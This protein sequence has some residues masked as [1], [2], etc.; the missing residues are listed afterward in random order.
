MPINNF[1]E[2]NRRGN[3]GEN[4]LAIQSILN[5]DLHDK[6]TIYTQQ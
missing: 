2:N 4:Q 1:V 6:K 5:I 3:V